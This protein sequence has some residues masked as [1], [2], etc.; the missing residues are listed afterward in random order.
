[1]VDN[2]VEKMT[3]GAVVVRHPLDDHAENLWREVED[4][5]AAL[6]CVA[7]SATCGAG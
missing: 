7:G 1:M 6:V 4:Y 3:N 2:L 5:R